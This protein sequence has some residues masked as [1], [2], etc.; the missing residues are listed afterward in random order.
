MQHDARV[1]FVYETPEQHA[2]SCTQNFIQ[3]EVHKP[4]KL[5]VHDVLSSRRESESV[6][7]RTKDFVLLPDINAGKRPPSVFRSPDYEHRALQGLPRWAGGKPPAQRL[8]PPLVQVPRPPLPQARPR[9]FNWLAIVTDPSVRSIR[10]LNANHLPMLEGLYDECISVITKE[11]GVTRN[12]VVA[13]ANYP[14][15]VYRL[16]FHFCAPFMT[17]GAFDAF[18]M[19]PLSTIINNLKICPD[20]YKVSTFHVPL[21]LGSD[22]DRAWQTISEESSSSSSEGDQGYAS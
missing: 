13:F 17:S 8:L 11:F 5:W 14:P 3:Q 1:Q 21:H 22:L 4:S 12:D 9:H 7:V 16:H 10:D 6:K 2:S 18:R 15:S 20:Y 19:H